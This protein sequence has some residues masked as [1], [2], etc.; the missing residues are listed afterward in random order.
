[1]GDVPKVGADHSAVSPSAGCADIETDGL[2]P[3][4]CRILTLQVSGQA[5]T[6]YSFRGPSDPAGGRR[7]GA[8]EWFFQNGSFDVKVLAA[9]VFSRLLRT[10]CSCTAWWMRLPA[11]TLWNRWRTVTWVEKWTELVDYERM[12]EAHVDDLAKYGART[13]T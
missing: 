12:D 3:Y 5:G 6:G 11:P 8:R 2:D 4:T 10:P 7:L 13:R 9:T 1:M